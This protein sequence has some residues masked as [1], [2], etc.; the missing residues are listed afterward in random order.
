MTRDLRRAALW[1][2]LLLAI[3]DV[4]ALGP[5]DDGGELLWQYRNQLGHFT[6]AE[7]QL[8]RDST[9]DRT[10]EILAQVG[11]EALMESYLWTIH[12]YHREYEPPAA[13]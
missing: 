9:A 10:Q 13:T 12:R 2:T 5:G 7:L 8:A 4:R 1:C 11:K 3:V 6:I